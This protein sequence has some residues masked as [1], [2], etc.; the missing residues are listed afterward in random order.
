MAKL[1][2]Y[3]PP[4]LMIEQAPRLQFSE[5]AYV[6]KANA[7]NRAIDKM[8]S[9]LEPVMKQG[10][11]DQALE[12]NIANP[13]TLDQ[14]NE[15]KQTGVNPIEAYQNGGMIYN[16]VI[17]T[18]YAQQA[19][20]QLALA[21]QTNNES[22]LA[23]VKAGKLKDLDVIKERLTSGIKGNAKVLLTMSPEV[24]NAYTKSGAAYGHT[25]FKAVT[26]ELTAQ[27]ELE[28]QLVSEKTYVG[29]EKQWESALE[30]I[31]DMTELAEYKELILSN[32]LTQ[33]RLTGKPVENLNALRKRLEKSEI[34]K[35]AQ[36]A[37]SENYS[38]FGL[39][40]DQVMEGLIVDETIGRHSDYYQQ[41]S[42]NRQKEFRTAVKAN[43]QNLMLGDKASK[44][45]RDAKYSGIS[46]RLDNLEIVSTEDFNKLP[47]INDPNDKNYNR[48][49]FLLQ[50]QSDAKQ[51]LSLSSEDFSAYIRDETD[52][53][54]FK[55]GL[56]QDE[57]DRV[58]YLEAMEVKM[59][60]R[61]LDAPVEGMRQHPAYKERDEDIIIDV[62]GFGDPNYVNE[63]SQKIS[64]RKADMSSY[65]GHRG[66][67]TDA[68]FTDNEIK[69][70]VNTWESGTV[71]QKVALSTFLVEQFP[72]N[73]VDVFAD[74]A[75]KDAVFSQLGYLT[76]NALSNQATPDYLTQLTTL[77]DQGQEI[78]R[79][80]ANTYAMGKPKE[81]A[82]YNILGDS[83]NNNPGAK[84]QLI[85]TADYIYYALNESNP[86]AFSK[87][88]YQQAIQMASG[89]IEKYTFILDPLNV[90]NG[91][92]QMQKGPREI[93]GGIVTHNRQKLAIPTQI[94][95]SAFSDMID[96]ATLEDFQMALSDRNGNPYNFAPTDDAPQFT[97][98]QYQ[99]AR[100]QFLNST[101]A[102]L[103]A[104][105]EEGLISNIRGFDRDAYSRFQTKGG[106]M[107]YVNYVLLHSIM[108]K[109]Y[110]GKY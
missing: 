3:R 58:S 83:Y 98:D 89:Q 44:E 7:M 16:Q 36:V 67:I 101:T 103:S 10:A 88:D 99:D 33:F 29:A 76:G 32:S 23:D 49:D 51:A 38:T 11:I 8:Q 63:L 31:T 6:N 62:D 35:I 77:V 4:S 54:D 69:G 107:L 53:Y 47:T 24:A 18:T 72:D 87:S 50:K 70:L 39:N 41:L 79:L 2:T 90:V 95:Q 60:Q 46:K 17:Q 94:K 48:R 21:D 55:A 15:A 100:L 71:G 19:A 57:S 85:K 109:R 106:E 64:Q 93:Y 75:P 82:L 97:L 92:E 78:E 91:V 9:I 1:P 56:T 66:I 20:T 74:I 22:V 42:P 81:E 12:F 110:P 105:K 84:Q 68:L 14:L 80:G 61:N 65:T 45:G 59:I 43:M 104:G 25:Y 13:I 30:N 73:A 96:D 52:S 27:A 86:S 5:A 28:Q 26:K 37:A 34:E 102:S 40:T 108:N